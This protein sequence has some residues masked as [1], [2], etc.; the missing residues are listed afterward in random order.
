MRS[1]A[2]KDEYNLVIFIVYPLL[3]IVDV[4]AFALGE[5]HQQMRTKFAG[6]FCKG[7]YKIFEVI[8]AA[9]PLKIS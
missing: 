7:S 4:I 2:F 9:A 5:T 3:N 8:R 1:S 6:Y